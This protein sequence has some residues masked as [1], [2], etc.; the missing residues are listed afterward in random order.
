MLMKRLALGAMAA[1]AAALMSGCGTMTDVKMV[2]SDPDAHLA[3]A[4]SL[5][6]MAP[7]LLSQVPRNQP[8]VGFRKLTIKT[9]ATSEEPTGKKDAWVNLFIMEPFGDG[10]IRFKR[11]QSSNGIPFNMFF[12]VSYAG[13]LD[14]RSQSVPLQGGYVGGI[15]DVKELKSL[16]PVPTA[17]GQ[18]FESEY[19]AG[20]EV[21]L[22]NFTEYQRKCKATKLVPATDYHKDL[23]GKVL[24]LDCEN[25]RDGAL[26]YRSKWAVIQQF[27]IAVMTEA[28]G[29]GSK[30]TYKIVEV[31]AQR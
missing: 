3:H 17:V 1:A 7:K 26:H 16:S 14:L 31:S 25:F 30:N 18:T 11:E 21:Q 12:S 5:E 24:E 9:E 29:T 8:A 2:V 13:M 20:P 23:P 10:L 22:L 4:F 28:V 19:S 27:G 15:Y 6:K